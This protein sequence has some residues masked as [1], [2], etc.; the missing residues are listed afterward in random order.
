MNIITYTDMSMSFV[1]IITFK[2]PKSGKKA[3]EQ[4][5]NL[6]GTETHENNFV[7]WLREIFIFY[8]SM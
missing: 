7:I 6:N 4:T 2:C 1:D 3:R 5:V 8:S